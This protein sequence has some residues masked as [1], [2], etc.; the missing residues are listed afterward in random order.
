MKYLASVFLFTI[1][2]ASCKNED[3]KD[4]GLAEVRLDG[5]TSNADIVRMP[6][7]ADK[8]LDTSQIAKIQFDST[9]YYFGTVKEGVIVKHTFQFKNVGTVPLLITDVRTT[10]GCTVPT[11][12]KNPIAVGATDKIDVSFNTENKQNE[13]V[14]KITILANTFP[15]ETVT[16][17]MGKVEPKN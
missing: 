8:P 14:K 6:I 12:T 5:K 1:F 17:M 2:I 10:C 7:S 9:D 15:S 3:K 4:N 16:V 11:W 13:Q